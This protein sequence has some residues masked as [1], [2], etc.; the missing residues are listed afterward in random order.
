MNMS[1][2][3]R[4]S[5]GGKGKLFAAT[6]QAA[7]DVDCKIELSGAWIDGP[8]PDG[9]NRRPEWRKAK[10]TVVLG[11]QAPG[12]LD[13]TTE[14]LLVLDSQVECRVRA[15]RRQKSHTYDVEGTVTR[16]PV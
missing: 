6:D 15:R 11:T 10:G 8:T 9:R 2:D 12:P 14:Y 3:I 5:F 7:L 13:P 1:R 4:R 16:P